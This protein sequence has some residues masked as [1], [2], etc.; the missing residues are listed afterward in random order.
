[1]KQVEV[2]VNEFVIKPNVGLV[3]RGIT[4]L[5]SGCAL[6]IALFCFEPESAGKFSAGDIAE[7][8]FVCVCTVGFWVLGT[9][10]ILK[11]CIT[12]VVDGYGVLRKGLFSYKSLSWAEILDYG[13]FYDVNIR[14]LHGTYVIYFSPEKLK[15]DKTGKQKKVGGRAIRTYLSAPD[16]CTTVDSLIPFCRRFADC[17]LFLSDTNYLKK[18]Q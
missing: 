3:L 6:L 5:L 16:A 10:D 14:S 15:A 12:V 9:A 11:N 13:C 4:A 2:K 17:E 8:L 7:I 1:M 18:F